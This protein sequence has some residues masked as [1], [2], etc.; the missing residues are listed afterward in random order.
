MPYMDAI[1]AQLIMG[2]GP[3]EEPGDEAASLGLAAIVFLQGRMGCGA[4][5]TGLVGLAHGAPS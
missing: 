3:I 4:S 1:N 2:C 5:N